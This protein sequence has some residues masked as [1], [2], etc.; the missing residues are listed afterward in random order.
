MILHESSNYQ[1]FTCLIL[2]YDSLLSELQQRVQG[3][4]YCMLVRRNIIVLL[5]LYIPLLQF[6]PQKN[7]RGEWIFPPGR[8][9]EDSALG[10]QKARTTYQHSL[11]TICTESIQ[12]CR[13]IKVQY[14]IET[15]NVLLPKLWSLQAGGGQ[16][17]LKYS[18]AL[19]DLRRMWSSIQK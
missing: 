18:R 10:G 16:P 15:I 14:N 9:T 6:S 12:P 11:S 4:D 13:Q 17:W 8:S 3:R 2:T 5:I 1:I 19:Q 7:I